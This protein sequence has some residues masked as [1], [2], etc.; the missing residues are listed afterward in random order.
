MDKAARNF[1]LLAALALLFGGLGLCAV[2]VSGLLPIIEGRSEDAGPSLVAVT[3]LAALLASSAC[4]GARTLRR[5]VRAG[6]ALA[7]V[8]AEGALPTPA[9]LCRAAGE[10][11]LSGRVRLINSDTSCS[12]VYGVLSP[13]VVFSSGLVSRLSPEELQAALA[14]ERYHVV[15][16]DPL[17]S[18][19]GRVA[20]DALFFLPALR[21]IHR[22]YEA[23]RELAAD[24]RAVAVVGQQ[25][26]VGALLKAMED[27]GAEPAASAALASPAV[28]DSRL[29]Q[30]ESG[31]EPP[32]RSI[33]PI[34][35]T[36]SVI[37]AA[38]FVA[39]LLSVP[40]AIGG[41]S[42][43]ARQIEPVNLSQAGF[44]GDPE[45]R[46][47][48]WKKGTPK[49]CHDRRNT[50]MSCLIAVPGW[51]PTPAARSPT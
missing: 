35:L 27:P 9:R 18:A 5:E 24:R 45:T 3:G 34:D 6:R 26:L 50:P 14:H 11:G 40:L 13:S 38:A 49:P 22:R 29:V 44:D 23:A 17:R 30:L 37:G 42:D 12:F 10:A 15:S 21:G 25:A 20:V 8:V 47:P 33:D 28:M 36:A 32:S 16:L 43:L 2:F 41:A 51:S 7:R 1:F 31:R 4:R 39:L 19:V 46:I 48:T